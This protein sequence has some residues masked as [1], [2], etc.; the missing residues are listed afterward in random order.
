VTLPH[1][2]RRRDAREGVATPSS[3][4]GMGVALSIER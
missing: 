3:G 2:M 1:G 4:G